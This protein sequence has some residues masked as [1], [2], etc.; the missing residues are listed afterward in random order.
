[1]A[2]ENSSPKLG[3]AAYES[4]DDEERIGDGWDVIHNI[5]RRWLS[6]LEVQSGLFTLLKR[7]CGVP[8]LLPLLRWPTK[9]RYLV[10]A[11]DA[12]KY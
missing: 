12:L 4:R 3:P 8:E 11:V 1:M 6:S 2:S 9:I 7:N 10:Q 5:V